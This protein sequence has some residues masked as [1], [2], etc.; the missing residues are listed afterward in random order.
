MEKILKFKKIVV[1]FEI[2]SVA[3]LLCLSLFYC[4]WSF[5]NT[6][7]IEKIVFALLLMFVIYFYPGFA[8]SF[9]KA[10][11]NNESIKI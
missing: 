2:I 5:I 9:Y 3:V 6:F 7:E 8:E 10:V 4:L 1:M 11:V